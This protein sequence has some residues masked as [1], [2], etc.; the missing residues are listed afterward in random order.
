MI[1]VVQGI[2]K[3]AFAQIVYIFLH[4]HTHTK[5]FLNSNECMNF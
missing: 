2:P 4:T 5:Y 3:L 1:A